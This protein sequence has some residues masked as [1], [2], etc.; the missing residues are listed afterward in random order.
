MPLQLKQTSNK[1]ALIY[2]MSPLNEYVEKSQF[3]LEG[4]EEMVEY[5]VSA[6][7][8]IKFDIKKF[9][10]GLSIHVD[11][12]KYFGFM[13]QLNENEEPCMF[14]WKTMPYGYTK[15]PY[16]AQNLMKPIIAKWRSIGTKIIVFYDD[17]MVVHADFDTLKR[18]ARII[19]TDL[20]KAILIPGTNKCVWSPVVDWNGLKFDLNNSMLMVL[21]HRIVATLETAAVL[22]NSWPNVTFWDV[23]KL[24]GQVNS[25]HPV[26]C[27]LE[28]LKSRNLQTIVNIRNYKN[29]PWDDKIV[30]DYDIG[31]EFA[32]KRNFVLAG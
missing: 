13:Y 4:W 32:K 5:C 8:A 21:E 2:D 7:Y 29:L 3:K 24:V 6:K 16:L 25:M 11:Y 10:H 28:Q 12:W 22:K 14:A 1:I 30:A 26:L 17:G 18:T 31:F 15:A 20:I 23:A 9:Y 19:Q 27:G